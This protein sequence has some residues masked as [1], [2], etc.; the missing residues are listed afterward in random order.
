MSGRTQYKIR[1]QLRLR[2]RRREP[3]AGQLG[4]GN[5]TVTVPGHRSL[6]FVRPEGSELPV[7]VYNVTTPHLNNLKV[8]V[9]RD[10]YERNIVRVLGRKMIQPAA[11]TEELSDVGP[12]AESHEW[13]GSD[14]VF[15]DTKQIIEANVYPSS[16]LSVVVSA[17]YLRHPINH[18]TYCD[19]RDYLCKI[20]EYASL[21]A[22]EHWE[23]GERASW[24][25]ALKPLVLFFYLY[26]GK[27]GW[28]EG[29]LGLINSV[30][31]AFYLFLRAAWLWELQT[32]E[33]EE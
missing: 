21:E 14:P 23:R 22:Q 32:G 28:R 18:Y 26:L 29:W 17:G 24:R 3:W 8:W 16:G 13:G 12:H 9:G 4:D 6:V 7:V 5:G 31:I 25:D 19:L 33:G 27:G 1:K 20:E 15:V 10:P 2:S 11:I 30:F